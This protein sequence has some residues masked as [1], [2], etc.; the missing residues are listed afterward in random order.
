M[1]SAW[2]VPEF[3]VHIL[4]VDDSVDRERTTKYDEDHDGAV[5]HLGGKLKVRL[6]NLAPSLCRM[7]KRWDAM[8]FRVSLPPKVCVP[9][10]PESEMQQPRW[11]RLK[12]TKDVIC[13]EVGPIFGG[14]CDVFN[15]PFWVVDFKQEALHIV[16]LRAL[17]MMGFIHLFFVHFLI[18]HPPLVLAKRYVYPRN[19]GVGVN[20]VVRF[21]RSSFSFSWNMISI[22]FMLC[23]ALFEQKCNQHNDADATFMAIWLY[24][25]ICHL[26]GYMAIWCPHF[27]WIFFVHMAICLDAHP[28]VVAFSECLEGLSYQK[29]FVIPVAGVRRSPIMWR[30]GL[31]HF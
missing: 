19:I 1:V 25:S 18:F 17:N 31:F 23:T 21:I 10:S 13:Q 8:C 20:H 27:V 11:E 6:A 24:A 29:C 15:L 9:N 3:S 7:T 22:G 12:H 30:S 5:L 2:Y 26:Y 4:E 14:A 28:T 16:C